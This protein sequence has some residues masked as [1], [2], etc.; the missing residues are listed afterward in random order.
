MKIIY[1][2]SVGGASG[3]MMLACLL[4]LGAELEII[5]QDLR[6]VVQDNF[7]IRVEK[8][9]R[10]GLKGT[11]VEVETSRHDGHDHGHQHRNLGDIEKLIG[12]SRLSASVK[13]N[14][15]NVFRRLAQAEAKTHGVRLRKVHFHEVGALDSIID[16]V[17]SCLAIEQLGVEKVA[18]SHLPLGRGVIKC[19]HG[20]L[21]SPAPATLELLKGFAVE[22]TDEK[23]ELVTPTGAA[24][25]TTLKNIERVP[26]GA[27]PVRAGYGFG[28]FKLENRPNLL[29]ATLFDCGHSS[30]KTEPCLV[31]ECNLD[32]ISPELVGNL[33][34][35]LFAGGALDV[36][37]TP[38]Q[39][40]K[41][42]PGFLLTVLSAPEKRE[43]MLDVIFRESTTFGAR[44]HIVQRTVLPRRFEIVKTPYGKT[45]VKIGSWREK[46]VTAAPEY[47]DC[48]KLA[49]KAN[50]P[51]RA[52]YEAALALKTRAS[53]AR[54]QRSEING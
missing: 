37:I 38:V 53:A 16:I 20:V 33:S 27:K 45:R 44:E 3:D 4:D 10:N 23:F 15:L 2:D 49:E 36:F 9:R 46:D 28:R 22:Q 25:L 8:V 13:K 42:R 34:G 31:L 30:G 12:K 40:K 43:T 7:S 35:R 41:G 6:K 47:E 29:R 52:V 32:D 19:T 50:V 21:P 17:G 51:V 1:F 5:R 26:A 18:V 54:G 48:R 24:L 14:A 39:M 11:R